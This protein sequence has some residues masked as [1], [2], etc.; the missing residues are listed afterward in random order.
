[1]TGDPGNERVT[2]RVRWTIRGL[3]RWW[4]IVPLLLV[5]VYLLALGITGSMLETELRAMKARGEPVT[6]KDVVPAIPPGAPNA[7]DLYQQAFDVLPPGCDPGTLL[8]DMAAARSAVADA[9]PGLELLHEATGIQD[10][11]F[12]VNW[13]ADPWSLDPTPR[14]AMRNAARWLYVEARVSTTDGRPDDALRTCAAIFR[15]GK[16]AQ[17]HPT[18]IPEMVGTAI[19]ELGLGALRDCLQADDPSPAACRGLFDEL[20]RLDPETTHER[21]L[22]GEFA[23]AL[24]AFTR[25]RHGD[26]ATIWALS[27]P[28]GSG[29]WLDATLLQ[30]YRT[31]GRPV[32]NLDELTF[33]QYFQGKRASPDG[34]PMSNA[35]TS[36]PVDTHANRYTAEIGVA[37]AALALNAYHA[38]QGRYPSSLAELSA[39]GWKLPRD[40]FGGG[41]LRYRR[42]A[43]GFV[44]YS[45]GPNMADDSAAE[46]VRGMSLAD[47]PYDIVFRVDR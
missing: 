28:D 1:M 39:A 45:L 30:L 11:A 43:K 33:M 19:F 16:H 40:P 27:R 31:A 22:R 47:G 36:G 25:F 7:A 9:A 13:D 24:D 14:A 4:P 37:R 34:W 8:K 18:E 3:L 41:E 5:A 6:L 15:L 20:G 38:E 32:L 23:W 46:F 10:C 2:A 12:A 42:E 29:A 35:I 26:P 21:A 44:V 17:T